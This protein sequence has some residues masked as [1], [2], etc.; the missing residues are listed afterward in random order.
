M[1]EKI[2]KI[3]IKGNYLMENN[4]C[5]QQTANINYIYLAVLNN[6][7]MDTLHMFDYVNVI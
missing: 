4:Y 7:V 6:I 3:L 2:L 5:I 1:F